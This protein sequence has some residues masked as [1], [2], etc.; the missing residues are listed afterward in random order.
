M[1]LV[2]INILCALPNAFGDTGAVPRASDRGLEELDKSRLRTLNSARKGCGEAIADDQ[3]LPH[4][5]K[6][7]RQ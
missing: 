3:K 2:E 1:H 4:A 6:E 5:V 7:T